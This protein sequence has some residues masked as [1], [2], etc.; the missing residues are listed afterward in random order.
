MKKTFLVLLSVSFIINSTFAQYKL[1]EKVEHEKEQFKT[2]I[3]YS[4]YLFDNGLTLILHEDRSDPIVHVNL[5][6]RVG[7]VTE[8]PD[9][10]GNVFEWVADWYKV[11]YY[12]ESPVE[13]PWG[14][15]F[16][17][18]RSVRGSGF[19]TELSETASAL[20]HFLAPEQNRSDLGFRCVV[21]DPYQ[22]APLCEILA[23]VPPEQSGDSRTGPGGSASCIVPQPELNVI[24]YC[25]KGLRGN[26][27]SWTPADAEIDY[28][29][30]EGGYL[31][32]GRG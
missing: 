30:H 5:T 31:T 16:G 21:D 13:N 12:A 1:I 20:R 19:E 28:S 2:V 26:N 23:Y 29:A 7:S 32:K 3:P 11:D 14:P 8:N 24:T 15:D 17:E 9:M 10:A 25:N 4:K 22:Y 27:I 6:H 18:V